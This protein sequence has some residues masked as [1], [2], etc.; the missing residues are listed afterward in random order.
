MG[1]PDSSSQ[2]PEDPTDTP[3]LW[4]NRPYVALLTGET[5]GNVAVEIA[6][7]AW[8][9]IAV[10]Y[11]AATELEIGI[12]G[13]AEG[14]AFLILGLPVGA[15]VDRLSRRAVMIT[16]NV[17]RAVTMA[18]IP[19]M[20]VTGTLEIHWLMVV[21]FAMS[22][23]QVFF[24]TA[25]LSM[26]PAL[27]PS[28]QL[29][30]ANSRLMM[31]N[32]VARGAGPGLGGLLARVVSAPLL[33]IAA[34]VGYLISAFAIWRIPTDEPPPRERDSTL[35]GEIR[36]GISF[37]FRHPFIRPVA[38]SAATSNLF[39]AIGFTMMPVLVLRELGAD[40]LVWGLFLSAGAVGG[41]VGAFAAPALARRFGDGHGIG[42]AYLIEIIAFAMPIAVFYTDRMTA[43]VILF[44]SSFVAVF[45]IVAYN[46]LQVT[47][48][49]QQCPP[50]MIGRMTAS[51]RT[52]IWGIGPLGALLS[53]IIAETAGLATAFWIAGIGNAFGIL[54]V[55]FSPLWKMR[56]VPIV[57]P[58]PWKPEA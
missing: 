18:V 28:R 13:M 53:G 41:I 50:R 48:R 19:L 8:P 6:Q 24:D 46:I 39:G 17:V 35:V 33:P 2:A 10:I 29:A 49:Q 52:L 5:V 40:T 16:A 15:W 37:V 23:A 25:Y 44:V 21:A 36:E 26:V 14:L 1:T 51:L 9:I 42:V 56:E 11:L 57:P 22:V 55:I 38:L 45:G 7:V 3:S 31:T 54:F 12:L 4:R 20:W 30:E 32:E 58:G 47:M 27:V 34:T 43:F